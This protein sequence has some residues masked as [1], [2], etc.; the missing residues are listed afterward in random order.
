M[1][2]APHTRRHDGNGCCIAT[3]ASAA[4]QFRSYCAAWGEEALAKA[5]LSEWAADWDDDEVETDI[6]KQIKAELAKTAA[7]GSAASAGAAGSA[8]AGTAATTS[9]GR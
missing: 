2:A 1:P 3:R 9:T 5:D 4:P 7:A 8:A 6:D